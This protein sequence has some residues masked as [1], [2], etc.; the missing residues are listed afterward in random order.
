MRKRGRKK[1]GRRKRRR[2]KR[3]KRREELYDIQ[4]IVGVI[5]ICYIIT[6]SHRHAALNMSTST[7][8]A[9]F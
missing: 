7:L 2:R 3:R 6:Y 5:C 4:G 1:R 8:L 9:K